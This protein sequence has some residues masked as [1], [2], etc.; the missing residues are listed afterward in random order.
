MFSV[1]LLMA[2]DTKIEG[3]VISSIFFIS[4]IRDRVKANGL[5][6]YSFQ[7]TVILSDTQYLDVI[8]LS[9]HKD[10]P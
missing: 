6:S 8:S 7:S 4:V 2:A 10:V 5:L 3:L 9:N 1:G